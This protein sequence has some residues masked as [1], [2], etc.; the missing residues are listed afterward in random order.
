M[1]YF[2]HSFCYN[3]IRILITTLEF[4]TRLCW[5]SV[6]LL[7]WSNINFYYQFKYY[8]LQRINQA[9]SICLITPTI[10][11]QKILNIVVSLSKYIYW[12]KIYYSHQ[13]IYK[14]PNFPT[15]WVDCLAL[16]C[17]FSVISYQCHYSVR[18]L[19]KV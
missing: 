15:Q 5:F 12:L 6:A 14:S 3:G 4:F 13:N 8:I 19:T 9:F 2:F 18:V 7:L 16:I 17:N 10:V 11:I 1:K